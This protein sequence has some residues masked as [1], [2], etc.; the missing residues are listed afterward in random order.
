MDTPASDYEQLLADLD[1]VIAQTEAMLAQQ[2]AESSG[3]APFEITVAA[4]KGYSWLARRINEQLQDREGFKKLTGKVLKQRMGGIMLYRG[5]SYTFRPS[6]VIGGGPL[7][8]GKSDAHRSKARKAAVW[9]QR[10]GK[11]KWKAQ[12][13]EEEIQ[14]MIAE[15][16]A[17]RAAYMASLETPQS[18]EDPE[19]IAKGLEE[20]RA[21]E[22]A[23]AEDKQKKKLI[24]KLWEMH[25]RAD[26]IRR[27][28]NES[29]HFFRQADLPDEESS[30]RKIKKMNDTS[31]NAG[32]FR[33]DVMAS[34]ASLSDGKGYRADLTVAELQALVSKHHRTRV[35]LEYDLR[36]ESERSRPNTSLTG[37]L[38]ETATATGVATLSA[39][40]GVAS[41]VPLVGE[42]YERHVGADVRKS[43]K[44]DA[45]GVLDKEMAE[46]AVTSGETIGKVT[47]TVVQ[48]ANPTAAVVVA[49]TV[50][51]GLV[52]GITGEDIATGRK[53]SDG[54]R[55]M[56]ILS[57]GASGASKLASL[58]SATKASK[59]IA[60]ME[61]T[62]AAPTVMSQVANAT[63]TAKKI[64]DVADQ[65]TAAVTGR[66]LFRPELEQSG[67]ERVLSGVSAVAGMTGMVADSTQTGKLHTE[68]GTQSTAQSVAKTMK[69]TVKY[70]KVADQVTTAATGYSF[71]KEKEMDTKARIK[72]AGGA[73]TTI[74]KDVN[75][76]GDAIASD[77]ADAVNE[78][79]SKEK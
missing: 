55:A 2:D 27:D 64:A 35:G 4:G 11:A 8:G 51:H 28:A 49:D 24:D 13:Q 78:A 54:E 25:R 79:F 71:V 7:S 10:E 32:D 18:M 36:L 20:D 16:A 53:M 66:R 67:T 12:K 21:R 9:W 17:A 41:E 3:D 33:T 45:M 73:A 77:V 65:G 61:G 46:H 75:A 43:L 62:K 69:D 14:K 37:A 60:A 1:R 56:S 72:A 39:L 74:G 76:A 68:L 22:V 19:V 30:E 34:L 5:A 40:N 15:Q 44:R 26:Q 47:A 70:T 38:V 23:A 59:A 57:A 6:E 31:K 42:L 29:A 58:D 48:V 63:G 50:G 52:E